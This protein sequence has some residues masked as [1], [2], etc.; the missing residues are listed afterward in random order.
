MGT[1]GQPLRD[2]ERF[3]QYWAIASMLLVLVT[4]RLWLPAWWTQ[5]EYYPSIPLV[6]VP[7]WLSVGVSMLLV[8]VLSVASTILVL[9]PRSGRCLRAAWLAI[10]TAL[11]L[12]FLTDQHRLQ[13]WAYQTFLY[14]WMFVWLPATLRIHAFR[15][16]TLSIY[17][18]SSIGKFD[19]QFL[20]T[21]GQEFLVTAADL[22]HWDWSAWSDRSRL[23][24]AAGFPSAELAIAILLAVPRTR[25][26]GGCLAIAMHA[27]VIALLSP[28]GLNHSSGVIAWNVVLA[29]QA[30]WLF[31]RRPSTTADVVSVGRYR[32]LGVTLAGSMILLALTLPLTERRGRDDPDAWHWDHWLSWAL[33]SPH[34]SRVDVEVY[35]G[36]VDSLPPALQSAIVEDT[37]GDSWRELDLGRLSLDARGV[38]ILPQ[39]R[40]Q[41]QLAIAIAQAQGWTHEI[42]AVARSVSNRR[43]G[44]RTEIWMNHLEAMQ[45]AAR[46]RGPVR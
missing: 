40:Y 1:P 9:V 12:G 3:S 27:S 45:K 6:A 25:S 4:Y 16:L 34:N 28:W 20:H 38:P 11:L 30:Y 23:I 21:V 26:W 8:P 7:H 10:A 13:P 15:I 19:Y 5:A 32:S 41:L 17:F 42:R 46:G 44:T 35:G 24:M 29:G 37:D 31:V 39:A 2:D 22:A 14:A 43:D 18:Y 36:I 33:Y